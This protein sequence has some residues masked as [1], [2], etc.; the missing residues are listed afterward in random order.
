MPRPGPRPYE[1]V[2][3]AWHSD[4]HQPIRGSII[5]QIFRFWVFYVV[6]FL[7]YA[8]F[9]SVFIK[10]SCILWL[11]TMCLIRLVTESHSA[12]TKKNREWQEKL[13]V[14]VLKA[15]E[16]MYSK[17]NS[18]AEYMNLETLWDRANDA[19]NTYIRRD[20]SNES[21]EL[22]PPCVEVRASRSQRHANPRT[23][24]TPRAQEPASASPKILD[25]TVNERCLQ[26]SPLSAGDQLNYARD[27]PAV[28]PALPLAQSNFHATGNSNFASPCS[29]PFIYENI[30]EGHNQ[31][32]A[33]LKLGSVYPLYYGSYH[34]P[35]RST[36][37]SQ[38][39]EHRNTKPIFVGK[40]VGTAAVDRAETSGLQNLFSC[41]S[42]GRVAQVI[43]QADSKDMPGK[44]LEKECD[45]S[46]RLGLSSDLCM[47]LEKSL[48]PETEDVGSSCSEGGKSTA[49]SSQ[50]NK[51]YCFFPQKTLDDPYESCSSIRKR[52][53]PYGGNSEDD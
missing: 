11:H 18:E 30:S 51:E 33:Q 14:V 29:Y 26:L 36:V 24:L 52:K 40:P 17:A 45:L 22:L 27:I 8:D 50:R 49:L 53:A 43:R 32:N 13:P 41:S 5:Q 10:F 15:E 35:E 16:I 48:T 7:R 39:P 3:R 6:S 25:K 28:N 4:R 19:I 2:R 23:Y 12:A 31:M 47:S 44:P 34:Q 42:S 38:V 9:G 37:G 46:L 20:E 1:C 21:G